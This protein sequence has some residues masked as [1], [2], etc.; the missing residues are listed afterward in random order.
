MVDVTLMCALVREGGVDVFPVDIDD[1]KT[2]GHLKEKITEKN[3]DIT[4][5]A[6]KLQLFLAKKGDAW[7]NGAGAAAVTFDEHGTPQGF[8]QMD[9]LLWLKNAK[10]FGENFKPD[11]GEVHVL[12]VVPE[13]G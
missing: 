10:Y 1:R 13:G 6:R 4:V 5:P 12:V 8:E 9:P 3:Y 11:E 7:L 2:V